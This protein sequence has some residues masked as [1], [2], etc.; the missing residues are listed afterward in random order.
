MYRIKR[1]ADKMGK[2]FLINTWCRKEGKDK[3]D[4]SGAAWASEYDRKAVNKLDNKA[5]DLTEVCA[6]MNEH[7]SSPASN[8]A[9]C[10]ER[11]TFITPPVVHTLSEFKSIPKTRAN[12][13]FLVRPHCNDIEF[14]KYTCTSCEPCLTGNF[15]ECTNIHC[16]SW[17]TYTIQQKPARA[18]AAVT[19]P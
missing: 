4:N 5:D 2:Q 11:L 14:R 10:K 16:G 8:S 15:L 13:C 19:T 6:Y 1:I 7:F 3:Y 18:R 9:R 17:K 12:H